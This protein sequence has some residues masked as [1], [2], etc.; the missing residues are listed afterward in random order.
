MDEE[1]EVATI[2]ITNKR[3]AGKSLCLAWVG[4][5]YHAMGYPVSTNMKG[6]SWWAS[7]HADPISL[8]SQSGVILGDEFYVPGDRRASMTWDVRI[9]GYLL[10][11]GRKHGEGQWPNLTFVCLPWNLER[12][13][14]VDIRM[15][16]FFDYEWMPVYDREEDMMVV[17]RE[18][19][20][21]QGREDME[22]MVIP[23]PLRRGYGDLFDT[24]EKLLP[25][26][27]EDMIAKRTG[28]VTT[29]EA[30]R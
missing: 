12:L 3:G 8:F 9:L 5:Y 26:K 28:P 30:F 21:D 6:M 16:P 2:A 24:Y 13:Q 15:Q 17:Y 4:W 22:P 27:I 1:P 23:Y 20:E 25:K 7:Y 11:Q 29:L 19:I 14:A 18:K 10:A